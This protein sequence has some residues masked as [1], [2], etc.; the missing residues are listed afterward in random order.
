SK[1]LGDVDGALKG[2]AGLI[3]AEHVGPRDTPTDQIITR[4]LVFILAGREGIHVPARDDDGF[5]LNA[6]QT[7]G[8]IKPAEHAFVD[9][10]KWDQTSC[11][12]RAAGQDDDGIVGPDLRR[13]SERSVSSFEGISK[14]IAKNTAV[15]RQDQARRQ[16]QEF[17]C[18]AASPADENSEQ[19]DEPD[20]R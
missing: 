9:A 2:V 10:G 7:P 1:E 8:F 15:H 14:Q 13:I 3:L 16:E 11:G 4:D 20:H 12:Y 6:V 18:P 19:Q 5:W 17:A